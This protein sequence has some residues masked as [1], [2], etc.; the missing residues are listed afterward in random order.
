MRVRGGEEPAAKGRRFD[1]SLCDLLVSLEYRVVLRHRYGLDMVADP[2]VTRDDNIHPLLAPK[3]RT[4]FEFKAGGDSFAIEA[5]ARTL[6]HKVLGLYGSK[7]AYLRKVRTAVLASERH[8]SDS[9][10]QKIRIKYNVQIWDSRTILFLASKLYTR[11]QLL[12]L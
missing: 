1:D 8:I 9:I 10:K 7:K 11:N 5:A 6:S 12:K 2:P 4:A 3:D